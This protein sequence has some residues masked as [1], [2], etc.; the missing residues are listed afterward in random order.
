MKYLIIGLG[1]PGLEYEKNRHNIGFNILDIFASKSNTNFTINRYA[2]IAEV[3]FKGR[4]L[5]LIKPNTFMNLSGKAV[6]YWIQKLKIDIDKIL[7]VTDDISLPFGELRMR[8][9][10]SDGGHNG[11]KDIDIV[12]DHN[13]Y[14]RLRF[15][16]GNN[17]KTGRKATYVLSNFSNDENTLIPERTD[18]AIKMIEGFATIGID[19]T[20]SLFN[21][22]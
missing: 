19:R 20:M 3:K 13:N 10:G 7:V 8:K 1:N 21:G 17:F 15:G 11:L 14:A 6:N 4:I 16:I 9:K 5:V 18:L 22:K 12:L 2:E